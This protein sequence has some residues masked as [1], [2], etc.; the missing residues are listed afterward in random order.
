MRSEGGS[1]RMIERHVMLLPLPLS[2]TRP[3]PSP[4]AIES[5]TPSTALTTPPW[6]R[7][8]VFRLSTCRSS[9]GT[10]PHHA[11]QTVPEQTETD[12][13]ACNCQAR[14][15][16]QPPRGHEELARLGHHRPPLGIRRLN[17]QPEE[18]ER[19]A[20]QDVQHHGRHGEDQRRA[21]HI[22]KQVADDDPSVAIAERS[23]RLDVFQLPGDENLAADKPRKADPTDQDQ[24][25]I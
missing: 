22:R 21:H 8:Y 14:E 6:P 20:G 16:G 7:K 13:D 1:S 5:E 4:S 10:P 18:P 12:A 19:R 2:P 25:V 3:K 24:R 11:R 17:A 9:G 15:D 23:G